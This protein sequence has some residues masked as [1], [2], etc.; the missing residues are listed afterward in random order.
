MIHVKIFS[1]N[2]LIFEKHQIGLNIDF[3]EHV[4]DT[5]MDCIGYLI[6]YKEQ[7]IIY[8]ISSASIQLCVLIEYK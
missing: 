2:F 4:H 5:N 8:K 7:E 6:D 3:S 1:D